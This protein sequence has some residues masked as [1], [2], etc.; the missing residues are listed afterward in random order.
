MEFQDIIISKTQNTKE[1]GYGEQSDATVDNRAKD[2]RR[3]WKQFYEEDDFLFEK[4]TKDHKRFTNSKNKDDVFDNLIMKKRYTISFDTLL[5]DSEARAAAAGKQ[6]F[7]HVVGIGLGVWKTSE[8]QEKVFLETFAQRLQVL[9]PHL[10]HIAALHFS[11]FSLTEWKD[12]KNGGTVKCDTH[13]NGG[14]KTF[15]SKRN[16]ADKLVSQTV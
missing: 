15:L 10:S 14:I 11:W 13:P 16:P 9:I 8:S 4:V 2:Y 5:L 1:H 7:I 12:L 6:A 3:V